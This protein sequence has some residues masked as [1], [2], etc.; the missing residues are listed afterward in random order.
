LILV[1]FNFGIVCGDDSML[2]GYERSQGKWTRVL[3]WQSDP[4]RTLNA[5]GDFFE[6]RVV[7]QKGSADWLVGVAHGHPMCTSNFGKFDLDIIQPARTGT[8]QKTLLHKQ[9]IYWRDDPVEMKRT[10]DGL[11]LR[12]SAYSHDLNIIRRTGIYRYRISGDQI[13]RVQPI[14][15][16]GRDFVDEWLNSPW[17]ESKNWNL[18]SELV[19]LEASHKRIETLEDPNAKE[20]PNFT[21]G[22]VRTCSDSKAHF[23]VE[24]DE[25]WWVEQQK[26]WRPDKPAY[27]QIQE[28]N[29]SFTMLSA[30]GQPNQHCTGPD[31]MPKQ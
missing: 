20:T 26:D 4:D 29:N 7:Q 19:N 21:Y 30:S 15:K 5:F 23:Q 9:E 18:P 10:P 6:Y 13:T 31:I 11:E 16:N 24:L 14:A 17:N 1:V 12:D 3:R 27:F 8:P 25:G 22:P 2:L 28:G